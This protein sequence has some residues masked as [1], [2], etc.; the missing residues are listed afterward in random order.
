MT[1]QA[2]QNAKAQR[3]QLLAERLKLHERIARLDNE[4]GDADRFIEDWHRYAS[5]ESHA[6]DPES[7]AGQNKPE[8]SVD[9]PKKTTGNSRK[10]D[11]ASAAREVILERG[12]PM[13][14]NDLYPLLVERG[15]TIEGR[16][17][18]MVLS[19]MLWR[20][21]DQLVRVKGGGYWPADIANAEA[22][23]DPNQSR[24]ID[25]ILNKPVE[26]VLDPE[27]D[28][29]RDASENAG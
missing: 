8:P 26:E 18:Q 24:E 1:D 28:V 16:D 11:V 5:P 29:Y 12:I 15:M 21:R 6:A 7:A 4:I 22:G 19:T 23:Y 17:P 25:N 20:M 10:E 14:R 27:S 13:L 3:E 2:L 9:T